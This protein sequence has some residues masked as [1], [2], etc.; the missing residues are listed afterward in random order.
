MESHLAFFFFFWERYRK[1]PF[2]GSSSDEMENKNSRNTVYENTGGVDRRW[3]PRRGVSGCKN[4]WGEWDQEG[5]VW[6]N[7]DGWI[8]KGMQMKVRELQAGSEMPSGEE[9]RSTEITSKPGVTGLQM[10]A[11]CPFYLQRWAP[12]AFCIQQQWTVQINKYPHVAKH[13]GAVTPHHLEAHL[14][15]LYGS[16]LH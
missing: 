10:S 11:C 15:W 14:K 12:L 6:K 9:D 3:R 2:P 16:I 13:S 5:G 7:T 1:D 4:S 8:S